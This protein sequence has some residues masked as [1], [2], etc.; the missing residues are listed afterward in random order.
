M[1]KNNFKQ[2]DLLRKRRKV[3]KLFDPYF[4]DTKQFIKNGI[5]SGLILIAISLILGIPF[6]LRTKII[7]N[8]KDKIKIFSDEYDFLEKKLDRES[9]QLKDISKFNNDLKNSIMD[10]SSS[11]ALLKEITL[12]IPKDIQLLEFSSEDDSLIIKAKLSNDEYLNTLNA[13]LLNLSK[14]NLIKF[15][16]IDL[17]EISVSERNSEAISY[18][19]D[20]RT[21]V[22]K[23]YREINEKYLIKLGSYGLSNRL[24]LLKDI[25]EPLTKK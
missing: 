25:E 1:V 12:I 7:E 13:F 17:K 6:I 2:I 20:I 18:L 16:D 9:I 5:F 24:N 8:K 10:I 22:S 4:V 3:N 19:V 15:E 21:K 11:S 14:S 23:N